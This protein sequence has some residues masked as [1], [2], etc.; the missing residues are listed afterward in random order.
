MKK[1]ET[2]TNETYP[3]FTY[4]ES[5]ISAFLYARSMAVFIVALTNLG[6]YELFKPPDEYKFYRWLTTHGKREI[7]YSVIDVNVE[8]VY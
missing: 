7:R 8:S 5:R 2:V 3:G 4:P 6:G 1:T